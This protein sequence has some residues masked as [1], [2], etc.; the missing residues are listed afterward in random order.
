MTPNRSQWRRV[1]GLWTHARQVGDG[2]PL[3]IV[4]GLGCASWMYRRLARVLAPHCRLYLYDHPGMGLSG[5]SW[6]AR[7]AVHI[8]EL[9]D[10]LAAWMGASGLRGAAVFGHSMGGEIALDLAARYP[11][12]PSMLL[13]NSPTGI[14]ENPSVLLQVLRLLRDLPGERLGLLPWALAAYSRAGLWRMYRLARDQDAHATAPLVPQVR[15]P[16]L[17]VDGDRDPVVPSSSLHAL[18]ALLP[19]AESCV[20]PGG[21]HALM[22]SRPELLGRRMLSFM[23]AQARTAGNPG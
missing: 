14:P 8:P 20:I 4:P 13:L 2:P 15:C 10:H 11:Q 12:L 3:V 6:L 17:V 23:R 19:D 5:G 7:R 1:A 9:T 22:D 21:T 16:V 18:C